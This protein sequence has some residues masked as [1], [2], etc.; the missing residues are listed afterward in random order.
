MYVY[1]H[2]IFLH[3]RGWIVVGGGAKPLN[4]IIKNS[5]ISGNFFMKVKQFYKNFLEAFLT[6]SS[7]KSEVSAQK[8]T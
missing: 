4:E 1:I 8:L 3:R 5:K 7:V 2:S 6:P